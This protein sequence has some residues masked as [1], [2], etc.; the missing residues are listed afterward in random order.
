MS[1]VY[2]LQFNHRQRWFE[3]TSHQSMKRTVCLL[4]CLSLS[5]CIC[6]YLYAVF[7]CLPLS[8]RVSVWLAF[9]PSLCISL[10]ISLYMSLYIC[11]ILCLIICLC[12]LCFDIC[13]CICVCLSISVYLSLCL[14]VFFSVCL[15]LLFTH[16]FL[17]YIN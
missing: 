14:Q 16:F 7:A 3:M 5:P 15:S 12:C 4:V 9:Y 8:R 13:I 11:I 2:L 6:V 10:Y 1:Y 17:L